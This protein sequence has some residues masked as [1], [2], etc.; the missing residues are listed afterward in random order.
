MGYMEKLMYGLRTSFM[1]D[2]SIIVPL[3]QED[4]AESCHI[5]SGI[6]TRDVN[7]GEATGAGNNENS[8]MISARDSKQ[9]PRPNC[10]KR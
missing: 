8:V 1:G 6:R 4:I 7:A 9:M 5:L 2:Y 3:P 10:F